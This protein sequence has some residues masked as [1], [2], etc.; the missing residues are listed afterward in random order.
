MNIDI[1]REELRRRQHAPST[2]PEEE[3]KRCPRCG[4][5]SVAPRGFGHCSTVE[6]GWYCDKCLESFPAAEVVR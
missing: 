5:L 2:T 4:S 3:R 6:R 1:S